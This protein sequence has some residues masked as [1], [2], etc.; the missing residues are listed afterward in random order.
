MLL[1]GLLGL[2]ADEEMAI[3]FRMEYKSGQSTTPHV[4]RGFYK[5][6]YL[7]Q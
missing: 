1:K 4:T 3:M 5:A 7:I 6:R 2:R